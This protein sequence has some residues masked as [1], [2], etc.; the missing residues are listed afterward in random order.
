MHIAAASLCPHGRIAALGND[1]L[2]FPLWGK[3]NWGKK[4]VGRFLGNFNG[5]RVCRRVLASLFFVLALSL[6]GSY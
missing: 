2:R 1:A 4:E 3:R 6:G 5:K